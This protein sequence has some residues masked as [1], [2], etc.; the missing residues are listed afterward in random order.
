MQAE[1]IVVFF[2]A[3]CLAVYVCCVQGLAFT[4]IAPSVSFDDAV[5]PVA[6]SEPFSLHNAPSAL[7]H[8]L[9]KI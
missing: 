1:L 6:L 5:V 8:A 9:L 3:L 7:F 2:S 4:R